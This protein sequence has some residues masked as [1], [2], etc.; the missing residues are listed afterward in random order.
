MVIWFLRPYI[1]CC[2]GAVLNHVFT[3]SNVKLLMSRSKIKMHILLLKPEW[4][5][6]FLAAWSPCARDRRAH[7]TNPIEHGGDES[8]SRHLQS[9]ATSKATRGWYPSSTDLWPCRCSCPGADCGHL[10]ALLQCSAHLIKISM[11]TTFC[12]HVIADHYWLTV[13]I[14]YWFSA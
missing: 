7:F 9:L 2:C 10:H 4:S 12:K 8:F 13:V 6:E 11:C 3:D 5:E 14:D 1:F